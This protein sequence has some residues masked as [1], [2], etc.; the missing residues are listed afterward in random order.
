VLARAAAG[1]PRILDCERGDAL[2]EGLDA[3]DTAIVSVTM[4]RIASYEQ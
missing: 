1:L 4:S 3:I 2:L